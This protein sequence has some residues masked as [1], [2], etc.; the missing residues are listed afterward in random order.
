MSH[1][2]RARY[3]AGLSETTP[4]GRGD[5]KGAAS[6]MGVQLVVI[7]VWCRVFTRNKWACYKTMVVAVA[8]QCHSW[9][10]KRPIFIKYPQYALYENNV[11]MTVSIPI[12]HISPPLFR[13]THHLHPAMQQATGPAPHRAPA[14]FLHAA[15]SHLAVFSD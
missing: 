5:R 12:P 11:N 8:C 13:I 9:V 3:K 15:F 14:S 6:A 2:T 10:R 4:L 1:A 7:V